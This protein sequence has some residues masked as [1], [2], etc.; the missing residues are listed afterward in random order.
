MVKYSCETC[1]KIFTQKGHFEKHMSRKRPCKKDNTLDALIEQKVQ[2]ALKKNEVVPK[3]NPS[4][5]DY[6]KKTREELI[7]IC[8][9]NGIK[10][11]STK[12]KKEII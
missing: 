10:G 3:N 8:K 9:E 7:V 1:Q 4:E 11:Y 5:I 12:K 6:S 2:E